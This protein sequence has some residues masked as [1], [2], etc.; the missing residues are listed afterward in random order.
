MIPSC[1]CN[2]HM[3]DHILPSVKNVYIESICAD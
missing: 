1:V 2:A 3:Y